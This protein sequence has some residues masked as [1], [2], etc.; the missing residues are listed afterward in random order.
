LI[1]GTVSNR[2]AHVALQVKGPA[3]Q[4]GQVDFLLDTGFSGTLTLPSTACQA[5][6]LSQSH[7]QPARLADGSQVMLDVYNATVVWD[8]AERAVA[9]FAAQGVPLLGMSLLVGFE[10]CLQVVDGGLVTIRTF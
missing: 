5:L 10:V 3:G 1:T 2:R 6:G 4:E 9:V 7:F 8:G